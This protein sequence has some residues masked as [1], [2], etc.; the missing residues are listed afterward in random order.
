VRAGTAG[1]PLAIAIRT[2]VLTRQ[3]PLAT[4]EGPKASVT[5]PRQRLTVAAW[6][7]DPRPGRMMSPSSRGC[8]RYHRREP[9]PRPGVQRWWPMRGRPCGAPTLPLHLPRNTCCALR[10]YR[11]KPKPGY[12][13][14]SRPA[15]R[16]RGFRRTDQPGNSR[17]G[18]LITAGVPRRIFPRRRGHPSPIGRMSPGRAQ[19][20][21]W[22]AGCAYRLSDL[23]RDRARIPALGTARRSLLLIRPGPAPPK[24]PPMV[25]VEAEVRATLVVCRL[26]A[27]PDYDWPAGNRKV[28]R[29]RGR[30]CKRVAGRRTA[31]RAER[32]K[33]SWCHRKTSG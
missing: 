13:D 22:P 10:T 8:A 4:S 23:N 18:E 25:L 17:N 21:V 7:A 6:I 5:D 32:M 33:G 14:W 27:V 31:R 15:T 19:S 30:K 12:E 1:R 11:E 28:F 26:S 29:N 9:R 24:A 16:S 2:K 20:L 3:G